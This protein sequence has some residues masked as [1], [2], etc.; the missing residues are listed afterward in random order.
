MKFNRGYFTLQIALLPFF[1]L[2]S[3]LSFS[4]SFIPPG[5]VAWTEPAFPTQED[6]ITVYFNAKEGNGGLAGSTGNVYAHTG[7]LTNFSTS[8]SDWKHVKTD[9][10]GDDPEILMTRIGEDLYSLSYNIRA[11]YGF[12]APEE[13]QQLAFV[14]RSVGGE[15]TGRAKDGGDIFLPVYPDTDSILMNVSGEFFG[16][17]VNEG[18]SLSLFVQTNQAVTLRII[19]NGDTLLTE[20]GGGGQFYLQRQFRWTS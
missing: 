8:E 16:S 14:F 20:N 2:L 6:D 5:A 3:P 10:P 18:D 11:F 19:D 9:W 1:S 4:Q 7:V 17:T 13:V 15:P 12:T